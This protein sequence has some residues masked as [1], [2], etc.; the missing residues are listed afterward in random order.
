MKK[1]TIGL[2]A[3]IAS[4][5]L[6]YSQ[7]TLNTIAPI[8][9][10][11]TQL[12]APNGTSSQA[13]MSGCFLIRASE[14]SALLTGSVLS[15]FGFTLQSGTGSI[16]VT[17]SFTLYLENTNDVTYL[18]GTNFPAAI[19]SMSVA[20]NGNM[21]VPG[22]SSPTNITLSLSSGNTYTGG[23]LYVAYT[24][25]SAG[26][27]AT[28][29]ATYYANANLNPGGA[30]IDTPTLPTPTTGL[31]TTQFRPSFT[32]T[33]ANTATNELSVIRVNTEGKVAAFFN[34][35]QTVVAQV[36]NG[37]IGTQNNIV[38]NLQ[39]S[40]ANPV[41]LSTQNI[42]S[43]APGAVAEVTFAPYT[44]TNMGVNN[45][46]VFVNPDQ[47]PSN[48]KM[49]WTQ[50]V[51]C[52]QVALSPPAT[53]LTFSGQGYGFTSN[54]G[55]YSF[56]YNPV[57]S[58]SI[59]NVRVAV[60]SFTQNIGKQTY[61]VLLDNS[62]SIVA[63]TNSINLSN[64]ILNTF[65]TYTFNP[66]VALTPGQDHFIG[67]AIPQQTTYP[68]G[69]LPA[70]GTVSGYYTFPLTGG[71]ATP[72]NFGHLA[73]EGVFSFS[74]T[75]ILASATKTM[76]CKGESITI[77]AT[78]GSNTF[79][80]S[81]SA[82]AAPNASSA[83]VSPTANSITYT[84]VGTETA[85]GCKSNVASITVSTSICTGLMVNGVSGSEIKAFPNPA[86]G[87]KTTLS[88]LNG[89]NKIVVFNLLGQSVSVQSTT[90]ESAVID[91]A[92]Q[93]N[94]TYLVKITD[95]NNLSK[96]VKIVNQN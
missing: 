17:G 16:P 34:N 22:V 30:T 3:S 47:A 1:F 96:T 57:N 6:A 20:Y 54:T 39:V 33:A 85:S 44:S 71:A 72:I 51:T 18:K 83:V 81:A 86:T 27:F 75:T 36:K 49:V 8:I 19:S 78:G 64:G 32:F 11:S 40:G 63:T 31:G 93:P 15:N 58:G 65:V 77:S 45:V 35:Q 4:Y 41:A 79:T 92:G 80:W 26:P 84:V 95:E 55:I 42:P 88:G 10:T 5:N 82:G 70:T 76:I 28:N 2:I 48:D 73:I 94:G 74:N 29:P 90:E 7:V 87:G 14:M 68:I 50:S 59:T 53:A 24:W 52:N 62:G 38:V 9:N 66:P 13:G 46:T 21:T 61:G 43:L 89:T 25:S 69:C 67:L 12:R 91:L 37:S 56:L 60:P 23:G